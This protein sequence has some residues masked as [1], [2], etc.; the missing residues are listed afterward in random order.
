MLPWTLRN[1][2]HTGRFV[3]LDAGVGAYNLLA[4]ADGGDLAV[5]YEEAFAI[6]ERHAPGFTA[7]HAEEAA[8]RR[9][10][11][12]LRLALRLIRQAPLDYARGCLR[13][14][15]AFW[16]PLALLALPAAWA[17]RV[18]RGAAAAFLVAASFLAY[19]AI[20]LGEGYRLGVEPLV[21]ALAGIGLAAL[22]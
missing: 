14:L 7:A 10:A 15:L 17:A 21:A 11:A 12:V 8:D 13:R 20:G 9:D 3:P 18:S 1:Y 19:G 6:A 5:Q 22:A 4:A 16:L 2:A